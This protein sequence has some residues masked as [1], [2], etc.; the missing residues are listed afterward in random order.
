MPGA[1]FLHILSGFPVAEGSWQR[2]VYALALALQ[3]PGSGDSRSIPQ[4]TQASSGDPMRTGTMC[5]CLHFSYPD[6]IRT[7]ARRFL[8]CIPSQVCFEPLTRTRA[9][10][11]IGNKFGITLT[12]RA[13]VRLGL[14]LGHWQASGP[15]W[16]SAGDYSLWL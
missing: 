13:C 1:G 4:G 6:S 5:M 11:V 15:F 2:R 9:L 12:L 3:L 10:A 14:R 16:S 7:R 8:R